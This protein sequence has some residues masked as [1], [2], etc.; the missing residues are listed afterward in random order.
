MELTTQQKRVLEYIR[1][2]IMDKG[3]PPTVREVAGHFGY[4]SPLAAK[5]HIDALVKKGYLK[6][7]PLLSRGLEVVGMRPCEAVQLPVLGRIRAG[8]PLIARSDMEDYISLDRR[9]FR[10]TDGFGLRVVGESMTGA[11]ILD[12][13][14]VVV[15]PGVEARQG[16]IVVALIGDEATV[17]RFYREKGKIR[18]QPE[19]PEMEA[20]VVGEEDVRILGKVVGLV[21]RF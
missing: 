18:L 1:E 5:L 20:M 15:N 8:K 21:R 2:Y 12:G 4:R 3:C 6:K 19:N 17:K 11:G 14:T 10:M 9:M 16:D 7:K 13:D